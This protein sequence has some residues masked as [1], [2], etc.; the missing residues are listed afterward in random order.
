M[1]EKEDEIKK[2]EEE[3]KEKMK[4]KIRRRNDG[5]VGRR[6]EGRKEE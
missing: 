2:E 1:T 5:V 3:K 4:S 6:G